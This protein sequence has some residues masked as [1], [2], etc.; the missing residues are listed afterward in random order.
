MHEDTM[1]S[2]YSYSAL[3]T[4][5]TCEYCADDAFLS[6]AE[7]EVYQ[8]L[9]QARKRDWRMGRCAGKRAVAS[10]LAHIYSTTP[11]VTSFEIRSGGPP[12]VTSF[13][14]VLAHVLD[15]CTLSLA[16]SGERGLACV[17]LKRITRGVGVDVERIRSFRVETVRAF[18]TAD[19]YER[20]SQ[21]EV[22]LR[23]TYATRLW[24]IKEAYGKA[25]GS[26]IAL[27]PKRISIGE[28]LS[29]IS[30]DGALV[31]LQ[32]LW[33]SREDGYIMVTLVR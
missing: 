27:H 10:L 16:H 13:D 31:P 28:D 2:V 22:S 24:C 20:Y 3:C 33:T 1:K 12:Y 19:E 25:C 30:V 23:D 26:G 9:S 17:S 7:H 14:P 6:P 5:R 32:S 15:T 8:T 18:L 11:P 4:S 21:M 29:T